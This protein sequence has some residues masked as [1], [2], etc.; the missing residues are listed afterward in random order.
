MGS[1]NSSVATN[2][3]VKI[4]QDGWR[5]GRKGLWK[6]EAEGGFEERQGWTP[7]PCWQDPSPPQEQSIF[8]WK[9]WSH[10]R[11]L[12]LG[13]PQVPHRQEGRGPAPPVDQYSVF[14]CVQY[15]LVFG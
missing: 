1:L 5:Q 13:H 6:G 7:V 12:Q 11:C 10:C 15:F 4:N 9:G 3:L 14:W 8:L 2:A